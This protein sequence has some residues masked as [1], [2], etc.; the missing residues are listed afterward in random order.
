MS[1]LFKSTHGVFWLLIPDLHVVNIRAL[2]QL[3]LESLAS[4]IP[5]VQKLLNSQPA[6][7][8]QRSATQ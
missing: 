1:Q 2:M 4:C 6:S 5:A 7:S 8:K 3:V